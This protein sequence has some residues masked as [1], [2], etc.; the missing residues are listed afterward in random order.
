M[1]ASK[2]RAID[3]GSKSPTWIC[4]AVIST[5]WDLKADAIS[6][7]SCVHNVEAG[8]LPVEGSAQL[9]DTVMCSNVCPRAHVDIRPCLSNP[10]SVVGGFAA[11]I[12][13]GA[14][15]CQCI[16]PLFYCDARFKN[17]E[18][19]RCVVAIFD[20]PSSEG[21]TSGRE[22]PCVMACWREGATEV[23]GSQGAHVTLFTDKGRPPVR[24]PDC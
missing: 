3:H 2:V 7:D 24:M 15:T 16:L 8:P 20:I 1:H 10:Q 22:C 12:Y 21:V 18:P 5:P 9:E 4:W 23:A 13:N 11:E 17:G 19:H 6:S 14:Q